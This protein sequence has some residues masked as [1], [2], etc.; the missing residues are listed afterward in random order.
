MA[1]VGA[2]PY[3]ARKSRPFNVPAVL[4]IPRNRAY[5]GEINFRGVQCPAPARRSGPWSHASIVTRCPLRPQ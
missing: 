3:G 1:L 5:V 2:G 4:S